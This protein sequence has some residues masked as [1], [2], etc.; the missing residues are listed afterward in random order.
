LCRNLILYTVACLGERSKYAEGPHFIIFL[1]EAEQEIL[2]V[3]F[4]ADDDRRS[5]AVFSFTAAVQFGLLI[6]VISFGYLG[7]LLKVE[8]KLQGNLLSENM[9]GFSDHFT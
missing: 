8:G 5:Q 9:R 1:R 6:A 2:S 7:H 4:K 3:Y